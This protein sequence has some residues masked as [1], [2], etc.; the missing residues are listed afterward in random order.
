[1]GVGGVFRGL[2]VRHKSYTSG[3]IQAKNNLGLPGITLNEGGECTVY[4]HTLKLTLRVFFTP[5]PPVVC[6]SLFVYVYVFLQC[7]FYRCKWEGHRI[8]Q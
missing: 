3:G 7:V 8:T 6:L 5:I 1:M 2:Y 4:F